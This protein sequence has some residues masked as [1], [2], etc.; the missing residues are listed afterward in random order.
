MYKKQLTLTALIY[1]S[2]LFL[3]T[4]CSLV[5]GDLVQ[6]AEDAAP[7]AKVSVAEAA[8]AE[9]D[10]LVETEPEQEQETESQPA[11]GSAN[12]MSGSNNSMS[13]SS[14]SMSESNSSAGSNSMSGNSMSGN[15]MMGGGS[16][17]IPEI[18]EFPDD[19]I[20]SMQERDSLAILV[21]DGPIARLLTNHPDW[22]VE[23]WTNDEWQT[24]EIDLY[25]TDWNWIAWGAVSLADNGQPIEIVDTAAPNQ[26]TEA[27]Y[28]AGSKM[29]E[30]IALSDP[31]VLETL[32]EPSEWEIYTWYDEWER[33]WEVAFYRG[34]DEFGV[35]IE[36]YDDEW[37][38]GEITNLALLEEEQ[39]ISDN[40]SRAIDLAWQAEGIDDALFSEDVEW[41]TIVTDLG[42]AEYGV[43][44]VTTDQELFFALVDIDAEQVLE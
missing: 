18:T 41:S 15:N 10:G 32:G 37:Q 6:T 29:A 7:I 8:Q 28:T 24:M 13:G 4:A 33:T 21:T 17:P 40:Q 30:E 23:M 12:N 20:D 38:V 36:E 42:G 9:N 44:F 43:S 27:E 3:F 19:D 26:L 25:D 22:H 14:N 39:Q 1:L 31:A 34:L 35:S 5:D 2:F 11:V 16:Q